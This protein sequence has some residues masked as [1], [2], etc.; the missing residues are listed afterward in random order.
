[1]LLR[2]FSILKN[3]SLLHFMM[4]M[5]IEKGMLG[6]RKNVTAEMLIKYLENVQKPI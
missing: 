2:M 5:M 4:H 3:T 1:M 6:Q